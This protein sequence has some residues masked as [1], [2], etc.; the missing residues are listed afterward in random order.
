MRKMIK[1]AACNL[2]LCAAVNVQAAQEGSAARF[3]NTM[4]SS[5]PFEK[6]VTLSSAGLLRVSNFST[7][8]LD[9]MQK[10]VEEL[11]REQQSLTKQL[12]D[13]DRQISELQRTVDDL[14]RKVH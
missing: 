2:L 8:D 5:Y 6:V 4:R 13:K 11:K 7:N 10:D 12:E 9:T 1:I 3:D 14:N